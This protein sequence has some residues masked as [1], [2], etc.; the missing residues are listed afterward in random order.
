MKKNEAFTLVELLISLSIF[1][2]IMI[3][4]YSAFST[5]IGGLRKI[6]SSALACESG[7]FALERINKDLR[8]SFA[9]LPDNVKFSGNGAGLSF[10]TR[11]P[12]FSFVKYSLGDKTL[13]RLVRTNQDALKDSSETKPRIL[14]K[15]VA[16]A[17]FTYIYP[18]P[19]SGEL[20][21]TDIWNDPSALPAAVRVE[22]TLEGKKESP[23]IR[24]I[25][26]PG[27]K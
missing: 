25:Y 4:L 13:F 27:A 11:L 24:T 5:G 9:Y 20:K 10:L 22:I 8:N 1:A 17:S 15:N 26:L 2:V 23:F 18:D 7:Y 12:D 16:T 19:A 6:E 14:A 21:E 3:A